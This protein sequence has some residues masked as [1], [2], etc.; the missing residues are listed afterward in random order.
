MHLVGSAH[1][2]VACAKKNLVP[3]RRWSSDG[4]YHA[5][6]DK[7]V[8]FPDYL[9]MIAPDQYEL[10]DFGG[11]RRLERF[12]SMIVDRPCPVAAG[13][14]QTDS[15]QQAD[16]YYDAAKHQWSGVEPLPNSWSLRWESLSL[17]L[18]PTPAG[19]IG[20]FPEQH[21]NWQFIRD[22]LARRDRAK[23]LNLFGYTGASTL[24][25]ASGNAEVVHVDASKPVVAWARKNAQQSGFEDAPIRW[26]VEDAVKFVQREV[27]RSNRYDAIILD[28]P[29]YGHGPRKEAWK[30]SRDLF[31]LLQDCR[32]LLTKN[33]AFFLL[34]CH[35]PGFGAAELSAALSTCIFG[36]CAASVKTRNLS[37]SCRDGRRLF[38]GHAAYWP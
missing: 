18:E 7:P 29:T 33:P 5:K 19:Q 15:W 6:P 3:D 34:S 12:A 28:P 11:G 20:V 30:L 8:V 22:R 4:S 31:G 38:A 37:L 25:A 17:T 9:L 13:L 35:T 2:G 24:A 26:I 21:V 36:S 16:L 32:A 14:P 1:G 10:L 27:K 23:V